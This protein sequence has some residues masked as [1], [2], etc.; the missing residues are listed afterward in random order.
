MLEDLGYVK[1]AM[2]GNDPSDAGAEAKHL[3]IMRDGGALPWL[4]GIFSFTGMRSKGTKHH[5]KNA[6]QMQQSITQ[7]KQ[8]AIHTRS[9]KQSGANFDPRKV[10]EN[11]MAPLLNDNGVAVNYQYLMQSNTKELLERDT[12]FDTVLG[13]L[14]GSIYDKE[15]SAVHNR[16]SVQVM[17][18]EWNKSYASEPKAYLRISASSKDPEAREIYQMLPQSTKDAIREI[19]GKDEMMVRANNMDIAFGYRKLSL[20]NAFDKEEEDRDFMEK[21]FVWWTENLL[22][23]HGMA[24]KG[25][26]SDEAERYSKRAALYVR[27]SENVWQALVKEVKDIIVVKTG[28]V[29][30]ANIYSN[31]LLLKLYGVPTVAMLRDMQIAW[32]GAE[33]YSKDTERLF[34]LETNVASKA[35]TTTSDVRQEIKELKDA[36]ARNPVRNL[37][38]AGLMPTIVEDVSA[39]EDIYSYKTRFVRKTEKYTDKLNKHVKAAGKQVLMTHDTGTYKAMA[40][41]TQLSDFVARYA[42]YQHLKTQKEVVL[43]EKVIIQE[44][45]D[46][47]INYD[48]PMHRDLQY[49]DDMGLTPFLKYFMRI[50]RVIRGRFKHAPGKVALLLIAQSYLD[51]PSPLDNSILFTFG[52]N[53][54]SIGALQLP[55]LIPEIATINAGLSLFK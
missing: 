18:D 43:T 50:Q 9:T 6:H 1:G 4:S 48:V 29:A 19:W 12:R 45:S 32:V 55:G 41:I 22:K 38:E 31:F 8:A 25:M 53:P 26:T 35:I 17:H 27:R 46:A 20:S 36:I 42:L 14:N 37:I 28:T 44:V 39:E 51:F 7:E 40:H 13:A 21:T 16:N 34:E 5:G 33:K 2:V 11:H 30:L 52:N 23:V 10:K 54:M 49:L 15:N 47:F 3:Y 24:R